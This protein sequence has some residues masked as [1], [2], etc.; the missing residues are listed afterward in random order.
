M[1]ES[2]LRMIEININN[3][4]NGHGSIINQ[5]THW[6][7]EII[8]HPRPYNDSGP[9]HLH[10]LAVCI[11]SYVVVDLERPHHL[12]CRRLSASDNGFDID[13]VFPSPIDLGPCYYPTK[14]QFYIKKI[15]I[16]LFIIFK[17]ILN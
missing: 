8:D 7:A 3:E 5:Q 12:R 11:S 15:S 14:S 9:H 4:Q 17:N 10:R 1:S 16:S 13:T 2:F 6:M